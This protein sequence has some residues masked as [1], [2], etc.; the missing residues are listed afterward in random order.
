MPDL[1]LGWN[2]VELPIVGTDYEGNAAKARMSTGTVDFQAIN[3]VRIFLEKG[4]FGGEVTL[5]I[6]QIRVYDKTKEY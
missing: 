3:F 1:S 5:K 6:D 4:N 2:K